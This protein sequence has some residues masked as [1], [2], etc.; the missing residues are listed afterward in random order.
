MTD[1]ASC[2]MLTRRDVAN[3]LGAKIIGRFN[4]FSAVGVPPEI[5][6]IGP[7][8]AIP[9]ALTKAGLTMNDIDIFEINEAFASQAC[10]CASHLKVPEEKLNPSGGAIAIGHPLAMTGARMICTLFN[11]L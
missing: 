2:I 9:A 3:R 1:G 5:M 10:Y 7:A 4:S 11:E 8:V 6:G